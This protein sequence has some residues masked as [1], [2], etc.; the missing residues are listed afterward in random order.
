ML[1]FIILFFVLIL[2]SLIILCSTLL[3]NDRVQTIPADIGKIIGPITVIDGVIEV[4]VAPIITIVSTDS[5]IV[6][7]VSNF[8]YFSFDLWFFSSTQVV[9]SLRSIIEF[10]KLF[11]LFLIF[12]HLCSKSLFFSGADGYNLSVFSSIYKI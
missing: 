8:F 6:F 3:P 9:F 12:F 10:L 7:T 5:Y 11:T 2:L 4:N 1:T